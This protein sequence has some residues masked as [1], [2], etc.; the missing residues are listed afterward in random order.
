MSPGGGQNGPKKR[1][2]IYEPPLTNLIIV[3]ALERVGK[4]A[5]TT[6]GKIARK[7]HESFPQNLY[8]SPKFGKISKFLLSDDL[9]KNAHFYK[10]WQK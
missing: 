4:V 10:F 1:K 5:P 7:Y 9:R 3:P 2:I 8:F 6:L